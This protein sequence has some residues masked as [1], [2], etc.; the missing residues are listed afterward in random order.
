MKKGKSWK[1]IQRKLIGNDPKREFEI[2]LE[3][4][5]LDLAQLI[6]DSRE[7]IGFTQSELASRMGLKQQYIAKIES[8][9]ANITLETLVRFL[10]SLKIVFKVEHTKRK[11]SERVL[12]FL[13]SA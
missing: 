2:Q 11:R 3:Q 6:Y 12:Q 10:S 1:D 4:I 5:K 8:G 9:E 7:E 13:N